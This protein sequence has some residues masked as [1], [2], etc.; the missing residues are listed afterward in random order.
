MDVVAVPGWRWEIEFIVDG[1]VEVERFHSVAGVE[2]SPELLDQLVAEFS[3][4]P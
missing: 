2:T 1:S 4:G 3:E